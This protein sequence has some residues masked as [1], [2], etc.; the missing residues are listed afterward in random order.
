MNDLPL[1]LFQELTDDT[2]TYVCIEHKKYCPCRPCLYGTPA[3]IPYSNKPRDIMHV[4]NWHR[5]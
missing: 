4:S 5:G 2:D 3:K 1:E